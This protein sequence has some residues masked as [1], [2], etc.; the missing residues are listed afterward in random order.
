MPSLKV[1]WF[2]ESSVPSNITHP[3]KDPNEIKDLSN[4][5]VQFGCCDGSGGG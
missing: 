4:F 1:V 5:A 3:G 2:S